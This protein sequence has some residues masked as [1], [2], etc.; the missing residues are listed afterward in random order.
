[1]FS[2][3][4]C[5]CV[6]SLRTG[7]L[8]IA[9]AMFIFGAV[10]LLAIFIDNRLEDDPVTYKTT[11][12]ICYTFYLVVGPVVVHGVI[13]NSGLS[14]KIAAIFVF[15]A[16]MLTVVLLVEHLLDTKNYFL[17][18]LIP[19]VFALNIYFGIVLW[20]YSDNLGEDD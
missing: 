10:N 16:Y 13:S 17:T 3:K 6:F 12:F 20:S 2:V 15:F 9:C 14:I 1:M 7:S 8:L 4:S 19:V 11:I 5:C 18:A